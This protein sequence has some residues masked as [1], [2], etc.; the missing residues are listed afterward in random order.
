MSI[1]VPTSSAFNNRLK[2]N[3]RHLKKW[4]QRQGLTA[5]RVY[6]RDIPEFPF[7]ID[8]YA[9]KVLVSEFPR[10][11]ALKTGAHDEARAEVLA[12]VAETL[13]V[14]RGEVYVKTRQPK[15]WGQEQYER[16]GSGSGRFVVEENGLK[17]WVLLG[18]YLDTGLFLDHR[19]TRLRVKKESSGKDVL[20]LFAYTGSFS[21][22]A[23]SGGARS[24]TTVD[25]SNNYCSW[26]EDNF[27]L[28]GLLGKNHRVI[29]KD[30][31]A[32]LKTAREQPERFDLIVLDPPSFSTS[33]KMDGSLN[34]QRDHPRL[35]TDTASLLR[36]GGVLYFSTNFTQFQLDEDKLTGLEWEELTPSS[37]PDD[38]HNQA[39]HRCWRIR[40]GGPNPQV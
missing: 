30:V 18:D 15:V 35:L 21:V 9:G 10:R 11:H 12:A 38:F 32:F 28:N 39:I 8:W 6:D 22:Y 33:H 14:P 17:F 2:K 19:N 27:A 25:L 5:F 31:L 4:A 16:T 29:R 13:E 1:A 40:A 37:L 3:F 20:N 36:K 26:A 34:I 7:S 24:T 23:A